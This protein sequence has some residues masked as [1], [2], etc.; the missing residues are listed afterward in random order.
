MLAQ[1]DRRWHNVK[2]TFGPRFVFT[3]R[4]SLEGAPTNMRHCPNV[5]LMLGQRRKWWANIKLT[6]GQ[7]LVFAG[8]KT[9]I[10]LL[11]KSADTAFWLYTA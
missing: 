4:Q 2:P 11:V 1:R 7:R 6:V 10:C 3:G 9:S 5:D 8:V